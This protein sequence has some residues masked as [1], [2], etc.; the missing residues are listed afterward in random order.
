MHGRRGA[1]TAL[2]AA[3]RVSRAG[4]SVWAPGIRSAQSAFAKPSRKSTS[5]LAIRA[6]RVCSNPSFV[7]VWNAANASAVSIWFGNL[8]RNADSVS[9]NSVRA[10]GAA[11]WGECFHPYLHSYIETPHRSLRPHVPVR[12]VPLNKADT[13]SKSTP[14]ARSV[15]RGY[16]SLS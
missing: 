10:A 7:R 14:I 3:F 9:N 11:I 6:K 2:A 8:A 15:R 16:P 5:A 4:L 12:R 1:A 13:E